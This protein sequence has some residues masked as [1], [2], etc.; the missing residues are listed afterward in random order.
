MENSSP[1]I[2]KQT[3]KNKYLFSAKE[4]INSGLE[5][6]KEFSPAP[7]ETQ[8]EKQGRQGPKQKT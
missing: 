6:G 7:A 5:R 4:K 3:S 2:L 1:R 8:R